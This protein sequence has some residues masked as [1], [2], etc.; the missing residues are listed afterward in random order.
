MKMK[1]LIVTLV[2][3]LLVLTGIVYD[4]TNG[5]LTRLSIQRIT[6]SSPKIPSDFNELN[7]VYFSDLHAHTL[8]DAYYKKVIDSINAMNPDFV[9]FGGDLIDEGS[10][11]SYSESERKALI[12]LLKSIKAPYGKYAVLSELD[13]IHQTELETLYLEAGFEILNQK[14]IPIHALGSSS[15]NFLGWDA[16]STSTSLASLAQGEYTLAFGH[17]PQGAKT[18]SVSGVDVMLAGKTHGGQVTLPLVGSLILHNED[19]LRGHYPL[20]QM[21]LYVSTG[22]GVSK[23]KARWLTDPSYMLITFKSK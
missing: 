6:L 3:L 13:L 15:I 16:S 11:A 5:A 19:Y 14:L 23:L 1:V 18:L 10:Y 17:D 7:L 8:S 20:S 2:I 9:V 12:T 21:D 4:S 22:I